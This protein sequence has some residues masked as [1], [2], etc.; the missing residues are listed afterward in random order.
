[1]NIGHLQ[2]VGATLC[3]S[4]AQFT[5]DENFAREFG[6]MSD[7]LS[8]L[9]GE[10]CL[11]PSGDLLDEA[12]YDR[13]DADDLS[14]GSDDEGGGNIV[15][16]SVVFP[17]D[18]SD[19]LDSLMNFSSNHII[20]NSASAIREGKAGRLAQNKRVAAKSVLHS[21]K[22]GLAKQRPL[23]SGIHAST[24]DDAA[25]RKVNRLLIAQQRRKVK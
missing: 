4:L 23:D 17:T 9:V 18:S 25:L 14:S 20:T 21:N 6:L 24:S 2:S 1:M 22:R 7:S 16:P 19:S 5:S 11:T 10:C 13:D 3:E 12:I 15:V 8:S